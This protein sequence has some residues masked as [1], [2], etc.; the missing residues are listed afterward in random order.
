MEGGKI[1]V[2]LL[3]DVG[4]RVGSKGRGLGGREVGGRSSSCSVCN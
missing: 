3:G 4:S 2:N 1:L